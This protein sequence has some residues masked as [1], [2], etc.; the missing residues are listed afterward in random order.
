MITHCVFCNENKNVEN[1]CCEQKRKRCIQKYNYW[2]D[3]TKM[4]QHGYILLFRHIQ[5]SLGKH[6]G[7]R[8]N[9]TSRIEI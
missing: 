6:D 7:M 3:T 8:Q 2:M 5:L 9:K 4:N 1:S